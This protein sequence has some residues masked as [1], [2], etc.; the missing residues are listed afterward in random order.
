MANSASGDDFE[1]Q[2]VRAAE[3]FEGF[4]HRG[5]FIGDSLLAAGRLFV[6]LRTGLDFDTVDYVERVTE[7]DVPIL[8]FHGTDHTTVPIEIGQNLAEARPDLVDFHPIDDASHVR[9]WNEDPEGYANTIREF[10][11][12]IEAGK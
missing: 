12:R 6:T 2:V 10:L 3:P 9:A 1:L 4:F 8:L 7:L 11:E 5:G